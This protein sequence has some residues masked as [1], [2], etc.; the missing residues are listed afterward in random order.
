MAQGVYTPTVGVARTAAFR[1]RS[2]VA[3][4]GGFPPNPADN[5]GFAIRNWRAYP[6]VLSGDLAGNDGPNFANNGENSFHVV[7]SINTDPT[8]ILDGFTVTAGN[9]NEGDPLQCAPTSCGGGMYN[10]G[11]S[12]TVRNVLFISN[13]AI[14]AGGMA[15]VVG[16]TPANARLTHVTFIGNQAG[17]AGAMYNAFSNPTL[18]NV[19]MSG[20]RGDAGGGGIYNQGSAP[21]LINT[22]LAG[23]WSNSG[24]GVRNELTSV[25]HIRNSAVWGNFAAIG[26]QIR[27]FSASDTAIITASLIQGSGGSAGWSSA[28]GIDGGGNVDAD[29]LFVAP[30][31]A[32]VAPTIAG[33]YRLQPGSPAVNAGS[34]GLV[35]T[36]MDLDGNPRIWAGAVDM[37]AYET[38]A[39]WLVVRLPVVRR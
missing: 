5:S 38:L 28:I 18:V 34:N 11:G 27:N 22:T 21:M 9:A 33:N 3:L 17:A 26:P 37:G 13:T 19:L 14:V 1:L 32:T 10:V 31:T 7:L 29:P 39:P 6:T 25:T 20:N 24:G 4:Y 16:G 12:P 8:A 35:A 2:G 36:A 30:I 23:N 15:N